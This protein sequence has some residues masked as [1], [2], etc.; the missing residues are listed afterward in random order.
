MSLLTTPIETSEQQC[1]R[2]LTEGLQSFKRSLLGELRHNVNKLWDHP[3]PQGV[4][5]LF[6]PAAGEIFALNTAFATFVGGVLTQARDV[7]GIGELQAILSK[8]KPHTVNPD[9]TVTILP[10]PEPEPEP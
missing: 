8:V 10:E 3:N 2:E 7:A 6:G 4:L 5:D 1:A 9:G